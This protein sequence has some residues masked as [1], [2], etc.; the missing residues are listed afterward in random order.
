M[1]DSVTVPPLGPET[2]EQVARRFYEH[3]VSHAPFCCSVWDDL[4]EEERDDI[5]HQVRTVLTI[6]ERMNRPMAP[7][8]LGLPPPLSPF[9]APKEDPWPLTGT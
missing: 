5:R 2:I 6:V 7:G 9:A 3:E 1:V 4:L 8:L